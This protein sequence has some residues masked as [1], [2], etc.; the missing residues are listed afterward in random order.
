MKKELIKQVEQFR[1]GY[2]EGFCECL[3]IIEEN[4]N[5]DEEDTEEIKELGYMVLLTLEG[6]E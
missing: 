5:N 4:I 2:W 1:D 3:K 6:R